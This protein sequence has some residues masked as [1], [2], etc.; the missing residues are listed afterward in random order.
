MKMAPLGTSA[1]TVGHIW[2]RAKTGEKSRI[3]NRHLHWPEQIRCSQVIYQMTGF[4]CW[5]D[6]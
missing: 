5:T 4:Q 2:G 3:K 1:H 6:M